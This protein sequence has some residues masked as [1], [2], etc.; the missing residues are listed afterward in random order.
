VQAL[1]AEVVLTAL[2]HGDPHVPP[3]RR[4]RGRH[5]LGQEL[6][7]E[8]LSRRG[9]DH[10]LARGKR[11]DQVGEA[12][13]RARARLGEQVLAPLERV[14]DLLGERSLPA[15]GLEAGKRGCEPPAGT[16]VAVHGRLR[17]RLPPASIANVCSLDT[18]SARTRGDS[19][20][21][22]AR[23]PLFQECR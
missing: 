9:H 22:E 12:L 19:G 23:L 11:R 21:A 4:G 5:V 1:A 20:A 10:A 6:L 18:F 2:E 14:R 13:P 3:E 17:V 7:L 15:P 16:E 8:R